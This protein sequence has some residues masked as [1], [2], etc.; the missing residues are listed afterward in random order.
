MNPS[1]AGMSGEAIAEMQQPR[2][3]R[4]KTLALRALLIC[5]LHWARLRRNDEDVVRATRLARYS[6]C[7]WRCMVLDN[8][9]FSATILQLIDYYGVANLA[10]MLDVRAKDLCLWAEGKRY[11]D[12]RFPSCH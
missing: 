2:R 7:I 4:S 6:I 3:T 12:G 5:S 1:L 11:A 9:F 10:L 8:E